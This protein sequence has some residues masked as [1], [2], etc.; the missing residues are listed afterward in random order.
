L[1]C[2]FCGSTDH[3]HL[4]FHYLWQ[5]R[6]FSGRKC[7]G[8]DLI[9][10]DPMPTDQ[11]LIDLYSEDYFDSGLHGLDAAG[12]DY[13]TL[14]DARRAAA[15]DFLQRVVRP[16]HPQ[17]ESLFEIGAAMGHFL[18]T[19]QAEGFRGSG[20]EFSAAAVARAR[21]KF[22]LELLCGDIETLDLS[23][24]QGKWD[25]VY[26]GDL[27][28]HLRN[29]S[30]VLQRAYDLLAPGGICVMVLPGTYNLLATRLATRLFTLLGRNKQ[31]PDKPYH[32]YE[33]TT[34]T[35]RRMFER[36]FD[37]VEIICE[38]SKPGGLNLK[39]RSADYL[40]KYLLQIINYPLTRV[41]GRF[42]D[43]MTVIA[44]KI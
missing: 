6:R 24:Q 39:N 19:A 11:Q 17:A 1:K 36:S 4:P 23:Q 15:R 29:P 3:R 32:L 21:E 37:E 31:L 35:A 44:R 5:G 8:C 9:C 26:A 27:L 43:R 33:Y 41:T 13:E 40:A 20:V 7:A 16:R 18:H 2:N 22:G 42:G 30:G 28:E 38:A 10:L 34:A 14:A 12:V 25:V